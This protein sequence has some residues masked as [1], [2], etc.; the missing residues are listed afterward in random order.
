L[1]QGGEGAEK[2]KGLRIWTHQVWK[3]IDAYG[4]Y[5]VDKVAFLS[6]DSAEVQDNVVRAIKPPMGE[7]KNRLL[8]IKPLRV[9]APKLVPS[10]GWRS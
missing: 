3:E 10:L 2:E 5:P 9:K 8:A 1:R 7:A 4:L 6:H